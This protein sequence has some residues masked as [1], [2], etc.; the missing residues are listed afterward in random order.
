MLFPFHELFMKIILFYTACFVRV[1]LLNDEA[2]NLFIFSN[3]LNKTRN[4][5]FNLSDIK[6]TNSHKRDHTRE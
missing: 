1:V 6:Y 3:N 4:N 2:E 5:L